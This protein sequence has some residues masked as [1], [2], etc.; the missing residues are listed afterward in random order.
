[1]AIPAP[2]ALKAADLNIY[3]SAHKP[4][5]ESE[6]Q[7]RRDNACIGPIMNKADQYLTGVSFRK[8]ALNGDEPDA[9]LALKARSTNDRIRGITTATDNKG[10][11][12]IVEHWMSASALKKLVTGQVC[13]FSLIQRG[14]EMSFEWSGR[15]VSK[16]MVATGSLLAGF[17]GW[18]SSW[19][20]SPFVG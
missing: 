13:C 10:V 9:V 15:T 20:V 18:R 3:V 1:L 6:A 19:H 14:R 5:W 11:L 17:S 8:S 4:Y 2:A 12:W 16:P 7:A